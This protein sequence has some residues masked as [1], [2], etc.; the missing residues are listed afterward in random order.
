[1]NTSRSSQGNRRLFDRINADGIFIIDDSTYPIKDI[2]VGGLQLGKK[3]EGV[4]NG[5]I[6]DGR[7]G[8]NQP[9]IRLYSDVICEVIENTD[10]QGAKLK[11]IEIS[12]EFTEFLRSLALRHEVPTAHK[13]GWIGSDSYQISAAG[14]TQ[15]RKS[16]L[17]R[18]LGIETVIG[19][20]ILGIT[21]VLLLRATSEQNFWVVAQHDIL[22]PVSGEITTLL[23]DSE[24][25][26]G[27]VLA[28]L[29]VA[30][31]SKKEIDFPIL[32]KVSG[33]TLNWNF[34]IGDQVVEGD[35]LGVISLTP[36][37]NEGI[38][39]IIGFNS[40]LLSFRPGDAVTLSNGSNRL[41]DASILYVITPNQAASLTGVSPDSFRFE[42]YLLV[43]L[44][45]PASA[46]LMGQPR[47]N[48]FRSWLK[49]FS[50]SN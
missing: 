16:F 35:L 45:A 36:V 18:F 8:L 37:S 23:S 6:K 31:I 13:A 48:V 15:V 22:S 17:R 9:G 47:I 4:K 44:K 33:Q 1:M 7:V 32:S 41:M 10:D 26:A 11:F 28:N 3:L 24:F 19:L 40:P 14:T 2:S 5:S 25:V 42:D 38:K 12:E 46:S 27:S 30:T 29:K 20:V 39:A 21:L 43:E 49:R 34:N 50:V